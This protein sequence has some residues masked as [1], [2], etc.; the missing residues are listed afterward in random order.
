[1]AGTAPPP[2]M[3]P[4]ANHESSVVTIAECGTFVTLTGPA[5][6]L[7]WAAPELLDEKPFTLAS[8]LW[9]VAWICWEVSPGELQ[10]TLRT[11]S[12]D[13]LGQ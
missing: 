8:D 3:S 13:F 5:Y 12:T 7:R 1:M 11:N 4:A 10:I 2:P 9:A 6:T